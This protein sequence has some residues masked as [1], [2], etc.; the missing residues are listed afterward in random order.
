MVLTICEADE[1]KRLRSIS[2]H[3]T[4]PL[5]PPPT[6][7]TVVPYHSQPASL[8]RHLA[9]PC[10]AQSTPFVEPP[11]PPPSL[12]NPPSLVQTNPSNPSTLRVPSVNDDGV[13]PI[14]DTSSTCPRHRRRP[15]TRVSTM[16]SPQHSFPLCEI[17][18]TS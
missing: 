15:L 11:A 12:L 4:L 3:L 17:G 18:C 7:I 13:I 6:D 14:F 16:L 2:G 10:L 1:K 8:S 5:P 9:S